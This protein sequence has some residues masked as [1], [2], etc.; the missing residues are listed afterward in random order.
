[1][2]VAR[3]P[4][5]TGELVAFLVGLPGP[6]RVAYEAGPTGSGLARTLTATGIGCIVAPP[7]KIE[8]ASSDRVKTDQR[9]AE[10]L[11]RL[12]MIDALVA[13]RVPAGEEEAIRD[14]VRAREDLRGDLMR[15]RHRLSKLLLRRDVRY[16]D[17]T[18]TWNDRYRSWLARWISQSALRK[19]R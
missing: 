8:R 14:L 13:V 16:E 3:P 2:T 7:G 10:R 9:D 4:G 5:T 19:P 6:T 18:S 11:V 12:L 17:T 1:M 15:A